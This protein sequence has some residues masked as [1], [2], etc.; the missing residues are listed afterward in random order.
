MKKCPRTAGMFGMN[1]EAEIPSWKKLFNSAFAV[2]PQNRREHVQ[3]L[4]VGVGC[5]AVCTSFFW[6]GER[7]QTSVTDISSI[8]I[9]N[10]KRKLD[11]LGLSDVL[12][13][14]FASNCD[15][16]V[17]GENPLGSGCIVTRAM[18]GR[19]FCS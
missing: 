10:V 18:N 8:G 14:L 4:D 13:V 6:P 15:Y 12:C 19:N 9:A 2:I 7:F 3:A 17:K 16:R 1:T 5:E 11:A